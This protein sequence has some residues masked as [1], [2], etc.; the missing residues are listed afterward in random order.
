MEQ[1]CTSLYQQLQKDLED[2]RRSKLSCNKIVESCFGIAVKKWMQ[3]REKLAGYQFVSEQ[4]EIEFFK[5]IKP[6]FTLEIEYYN[7]VYH[8]SLFRPGEPESLLHF[9]GREYGRLRKFK[10]ENKLFLRCYNSNQN[11]EIPYFYLRKY[12]T[13]EGADSTAR[14]YDSDASVSTN[15]DRL[16][17][18]LLALEKYRNYV[19]EKLENL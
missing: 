12:C 3:L 2:C 19:V 16:T 7:L 5:I 13:L 18:T 10:T 11:K 1:Y 8:S 15:G 17:A 4:K 14:I 9:W 6:K